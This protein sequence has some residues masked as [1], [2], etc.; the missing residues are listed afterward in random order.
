M[1]AVAARVHMKAGSLYYHF[2][3]K[4]VLVEE[5][6]NLG[7]ENLY[8]HVDAALQALPADI[9][10]KKKLETAISA[11]MSGLF[12]ADKKLQVYE[13]MPPPLKRSSRKMRENYAQLWRDLLTEGM[14]RGEVSSDANLKVLV[15]YFLGG[16][17]RVPGWI[18]S[19]GSTSGEIA[20][21]AT[22]VLLHGIS[23]YRKRTR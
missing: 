19:S 12:G 1:R 21:F 14:A 10:F 23:T 16:L 6:L 22:S 18:R 11:H 4:E 8:N 15:P 5:I 20:S 13:H 17:Y 7:I 2:S 9:P 3:S